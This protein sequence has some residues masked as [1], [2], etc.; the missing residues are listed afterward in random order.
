MKTLLWGLLL[1]FPLASRAQSVGIGTTTPDASAVLDM[2]TTTQG[3][4]PPR[5]SAAQRQAIANPA[6]GLLVYQT[7]GSVGLYVYAGLTWRNL[8][9]GRIPDANGSTAPPNGGVVSTFNSSTLPRP[10]GVAVGETGTVYA[11][12]VNYHILVQ[13]PV[14]GPGTVLAG[15]VTAGYADGTGVAAKFN[16][17]TGVAV[18][19]NGTVYVA[20]QANN[21][22]R[23]VTAAGVTT[24]LAGSTTAGSADGTGPAAGF[25]L[26][27]GIA[28]DLTGALY[29]A[30]KGNNRIRKITPAGV[31]TT[32]AGS[33]TAGAADGVGA[34]ASFN[35]PAG[36]AVDALGTVY[37]ADQGNHRIRRIT[38]AGVVSTLAG[39]GA[40]T[41]ADGTG[42][43]ASF[44][45]PSGMAVD[46][47]GTVY[48]ADQLNHRI[49]RVTPAGVTTTLAGSGTVGSTDGTGTNASF[50][51]PTGI[52]ITAAG[53]LYVAEPPTNRI[54]AIK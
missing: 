27:T 23:K 12:D 44:N 4:L 41:F 20:D 16:T 11:S 47:G 51:T 38:A 40:A 25:N 7:D 33:G 42:A 1:A 35:A 3:L 6:Q 14:S 45:S 48:V 21:C 49:R 52:A 53:T 46:A 39:S 34:A 32:L 17:P 9:D 29:V 36:V 8:T 26:P 15:A 13:F 10:T 2:R 50:N 5:M 19:A 37:V 18:D 43:A 22:I 30:D 54:R 24:T 28:V 31:V